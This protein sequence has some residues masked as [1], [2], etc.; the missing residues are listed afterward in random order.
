MSEP[1]APPA[2]LVIFGAMG[3][4]AS[5]LLLPALVNLVRGGLIDDGLTIIGIDHDPAPDEA[6]RARLDRFQDDRNEPAWTGLRGRCRY[7]AGD[8]NDPATFTRLAGQVPD[9]AANVVFYLATSPTFFGEII[10][11]LAGAGL[12]AEA[13]GFRRVVIEKPFGHDLATAEALNA[14]I[15]KVADESQIYRID[16]FLGKETVRNIMVTRFGNAMFES[17]WN[18]R[19]IDH[20]QITAAESLGVGHRGKFY[21]AT[22]ALRDMVPNHLFQLMAMIGMEPPNSFAAG[23][24]RAEKAKVIDAVRAPSGLAASTDAVRGRYRAGCAQEQV[25]PD[26]L[27]EPDIA[28]DSTTETYVAMKLMIDTWRWAGVPFYMRTGKALSAR[29][30]HVVIV[31]KPVPF[32]MFR[33]T[34]VTHLPSNKLVIQVQP[35]EGISLDFIAKKPG[36]MVDTAPVSMVFSYADSFK[37]G[38][39]TGYEALLYDVMIGDQSLFQRADEIEGAWRAVQPFLDAWQRAREAPEEYQAGTAGPGGADALMARDGRE[40]HKLG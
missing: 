6:L 11:A 37:L 1:V 5:R 29:D 32:A 28:A 10:A 4:L 15:L 30:T 3:D 24:M 8:F 36:P 22:G 20:V 21:D 27:A 18:N 14:A 34:D 26:Y 25:L 33:D 39:T 19:H 23:A 35:N 12:L 13:G 31:F 17:L 40:W 38:H 7:L 16:H 2:T 9:A